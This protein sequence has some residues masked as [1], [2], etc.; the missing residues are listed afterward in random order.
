MKHSRD[1][2][3]RSAAAEPPHAASR[4]AVNSLPWT[5]RLRSVL[6]VVAVALVVA[7][8]LVPSEGAIREGAYAGLVTGWCMLLVVWAA[9]ALHDPGTKI[10]LGW[11]EI[12]GGVFVAWHSV[13]AIAWLGSGN[14]RQTLN[15]LWLM[16][17]YGLTVFMLRQVVTAA[18]RAR[19]LVAI[20][21]WLATM[22]AATGY[23]QYF[24]T[25]PAVRAEFAHDPDRLLMERGIS[26]DPDSPER[27][28]FENRL[29]S[30]EPL[31]TFALTNS[32][33]GFLAPWLIA[34]L[35]VGLAV[36]PEPAARRSLIGAA[37]LAAL[38]AGCLLLT[39]SRTAVLAV[40]AGLVLLAL[41][42][43]RSG[44]QIHWRLPAIAAGVLVVIGL[45]VVYVGGLD[46]EVLSEAPKSVLYR[47]EYWR[48]TAAMIADYPWWGCGPGSFQESYAAY[49]LPQASEMVADPHNFLLEIWARAGTPGIVLLLATFAA[50]V[51]DLM[52][53]SSNDS[54]PAGAPADK[55][56]NDRPSDAAWFYGSGIAGLILGSVF[57]WMSG[58]PLDTLADTLVPVVWGVGLPLLPLVWWLLQ[59]WT[60][61]GELPLGSAIVVLLVLLINLLAAGAVV[62]P[63][64]MLTALV[65]VPVAM[66]IGRHSAES[67]RDLPAQPIRSARLP[68]VLPLSRPAAVA[69]C[70]AAFAMA[71][72]CIW[73]LYQPVMTSRL[74]MQIAIAHFQTGETAAAETS[75]RAAAKADSWSPE[76]W[77]LL[78]EIALRK[79]VNDPSDRAWTDFTVFDAEFQRRNPA[80]HGQSFQQAN[81]H[82][83]AWQ[84]CHR[85]SV[86]TCEGK[87]LSANQPTRLAEALAAYR[88]AINRYPNH[89]LYHAQLAWALRQ[90]G[91]DEAAHLAADRAKE[92]D[93]AMPHTDQKLAKRRIVDLQPATDRIQTVR[94]ETAEQTVEA[95]RKS[96]RR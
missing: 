14:D 88:E 51:F 62:F 63:G 24:V 81:W 33:A 35:A 55:S 6:A 2:H 4:G 16:I 89:A 78:G 10:R 31:A 53:A 92:L 52:R 82:F 74:Q 9:L 23:V 25:M 20:M 3:A 72:S 18:R 85:V 17:G 13:A 90:A 7:T 41:Y 54:S 93:D 57:A 21:L 64:V 40:M 1:K 83:L 15:A 12:V 95:L 56:S 91:Q 79:F 65:I 61:A 87:E 73:T 86:L 49:K 84:R 47:L 27:Q 19:V 76:P 75:A 77:R 50:F 44:W 59:P 69:L 46:A 66:Q 26:T 32:L 22:L 58:F 29:K 5:E 39:K 36:L 70:V 8:T 67:N 28:L 94:P 80:H 68:G 42:G 11:T 43:R 96:T 48:S 37:V 30:V 45:G 34:A 38:L 60:D 71:I